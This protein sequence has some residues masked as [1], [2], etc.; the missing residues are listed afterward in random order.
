MGAPVSTP[1]RIVL[2][3][4]GGGEVPEQL[5]RVLTDTGAA[6]ARRK[7]KQ[8]GVESYSHRGIVHG[9]AARRIA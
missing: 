4:R 6:I 1:A 2:V 7:G 9:C 3:Q 5:F 8:V